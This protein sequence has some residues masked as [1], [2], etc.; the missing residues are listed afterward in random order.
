MSRKTGVRPTNYTITWTSQ[1][2]SGN[3][4]IDLYKG[5]SFFTQLAASDPND[6]SYPFNPLAGWPNGS[7]YRIAI[8][9]ESGTVSD[10]SNGFFTIASP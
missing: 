7:D 4:Q 6:G 3:V 2:V 5:G 10:F 9:A 8:S 1:N